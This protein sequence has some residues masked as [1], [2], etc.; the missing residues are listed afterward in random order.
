VRHPSAAN[1]SATVGTS[2]GTARP[3]ATPSD[4]RR[5]FKAGLT[6]LHGAVG[7]HARAAWLPRGHHA[8]RRRGRRVRKVPR[9]QP[10]QLFLVQLVG[11]TA[12]QLLTPPAMM[13][14][15]LAVRGV[16]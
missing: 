10:L 1:Q 12:A 7:G 2:K 13:P 14:G 15:H 16:A 6:L 5:S 11:G 8:R 9:L 4:T 3:L